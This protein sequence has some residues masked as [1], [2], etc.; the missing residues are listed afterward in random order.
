M[1]PEK[2]K[3]ADHVTHSVSKAAAAGGGGAEKEEEGG[4]AHKRKHDEAVPEKEH[5]A[6]AAS[7]EEESEETKSKRAKI[8]QPPPEEAEKKAPVAKR[9]GRIQPGRP[10][11]PDA[12]AVHAKHRLLVVPTKKLPTNNVRAPQSVAIHSALVAARSVPLFTAE[13]GAQSLTSLFFLV[14]FF[15]SRS[16]A[17][18][19][20]VGSNIEAIKG[21]IGEFHYH[22]QTRGD[23]TNAAARIV[24]ECLYEIVKQG[25]H[26]YLFY[27]LEFPHEVTD[28]QKA[29]NIQQEGQ[30]RG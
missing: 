28:V 22:T 2:V 23:R 4:A 17:F 25:D 16:W 8:S 7:K 24:A 21:H 6:A 3:M 1:S 18:V 14:A 11:H 19:E 15:P 26:T 10:L 5:D 13:L 27:E 30:A 29:F 12:K 9:R 20:E